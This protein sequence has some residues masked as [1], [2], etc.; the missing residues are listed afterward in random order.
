MI[1]LKQVEAFYWVGTLGSFAAAAD[2]IN[3][4]QSTVSKRIQEMELSLGI[5]LF[6]RDMRSGRLTLKGTEI[7]GLSER[8]LRLRSRFADA[9]KNEEALSGTLRMGITEFVAITVL[10]DLVTAIKDKYP[11]LVIEPVVDLV[12][13]LYKRLEEQSLD[14]V[15]GP[16]ILKDDRFTITLLQKVEQS[17]MCRPDLIPGNEVIPLQ[18]LKDNTL[19]LQS[20]GSALQ[21]M[22]NRL[23]DENG[24]RPKSVI[25][26]NGMMALAEMA[27]A[28]LGI[29]C[30]PR[31]FFQA[32]VT[33][34]RLRVVETD[35]SVPSLLFAIA[36]RR[37]AVGNLGATIS[38]LIAPLCDFSG[39]IRKSRATA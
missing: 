4:A 38:S 21:S 10:P 18:R 36:A 6:D 7:L 34:G 26:C 16:R 27:A 19:L 37:D 15:I 31:S 25:S 3:V 30:L 23:L 2:K 35:P 13:G 20:G 39:Q 1:T 33:A 9:A 8:M 29:T 24:V 5:D 22:I 12:G 32:E 28:G 11:L 14:L 17:W